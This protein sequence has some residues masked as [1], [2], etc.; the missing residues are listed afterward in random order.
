MGRSSCSLPQHEG[1]AMKSEDIVVIA[2]GLNAD[3]A[4]ELE[5]AFPLR[6]KTNAALVPLDSDILGDVEVKLSAILGHGV[7]AV[8]DLLDLEDGNVLNLDTPL[9]GM[10]DVTLN[11]R[12]VAK[13]EIVA[14]GDRF[15]VRIAKIVAARG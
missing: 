12:V 4:V 13:G 10:I 9:D 7:I 6:K 2:S 5:P 14:V 11:G 15:G 1:I 8:R 3:K